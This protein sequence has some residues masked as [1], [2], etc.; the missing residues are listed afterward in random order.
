MA[1]TVA[2]TIPVVAAKQRA[3]QHHRNAQTPRHRAEKLR[4]RNQQILGNLRPLQHD[5]HED[6]QRDGDQRILIHPRE[7]PPTYC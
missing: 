6:E 1:T 2:P 5:A 7:R 4:H 3:H